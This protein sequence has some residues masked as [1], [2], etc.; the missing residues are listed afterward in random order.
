MQYATVLVNFNTTYYFDHKQEAI[1]YGRNSGFQYA[2]W[3]CD[4]GGKFLK[5][6]HSNFVG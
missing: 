2:V 3:L 1:K 5:Q 4:R 6:V